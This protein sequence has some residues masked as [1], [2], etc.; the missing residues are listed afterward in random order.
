M[1]LEE[2][3]YNLHFHIEKVQPPNFKV[4][5]DDGP[6]PYKLY[7]GLPVFPLSSDVP[8]TLESKEPMHS[9]QPDTR[10]MGHFLWY[11]Y[12]LT[13]LS[14]SVISLDSA[15]P[16]LGTIQTFRRF[17]P[18]GGALYP[19]EVYVYL[20]VE[21]LPFGVYHYDAAHHRLVLLREGNFDAY[22]AQALGNH[23][24]MSACFGSVF[25]STMFWKNFFKYHNFAFR[26]QGL[27]A[28]VLIG[29]LLEVAKRFGFETGVHFRFLDR[30]VNHLL[31]LSEQEE[32]VYAVIPLTVHPAA[33]WFA[34]SADEAG[35]PVTAAELCRELTPIHSEHYVQSR[36]VREHPKLIKLN[37][38]SF[39]ESIPLFQSSAGE[40]EIDS[41]SH[42]VA[43]PRVDRLSYDLALASR[44]R[45]SPGTNFIP[46]SISQFQLATLLHETMASFSYRS[47]LDEW[48]KN[49]KQRVLLYGCIHGV[50]D[51]PSGAYRYDSAMHA[52]LQ[53]RPGDHRDRLQQGMSLYNVNLF[54]VPVCLHI[55]GNRDSLLPV[56]GYRGYRIQQ[57][58]AG[59]LTQRLLLAASAIGLGGHPLLDFHTNT[60]DEIYK[61]ASSEKTSLIQIPVGLY[62]PRPRLEGGLLG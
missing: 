41:V 8:L 3:L 9:K 40:R 46:G 28:G 36:R 55:A 4:D 12:G 20:K 25:V 13:Q 10:Q 53:L 29:Q 24:D 51:V 23:C 26:L 6:L 32:S 34:D 18:S 30:A 1:S 27:D 15:G 35:K 16:A 61:M 59:M 45:Y 48:N 57:M 33:A 44:K 19:S 58:E 7:R 62:C 52:L 22:L 56:L 43:L 54:Q 17:V 50:E 49:P 5:W 42:T 47:D 21:D 39:L 14:Q 60:C 2:F 11:V 31:G 37:E 38:S